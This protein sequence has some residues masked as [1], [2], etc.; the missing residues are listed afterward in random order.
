MGDGALA[1]GPKLPRPSSTLPVVLD[2]TRTT[3]TK[4]LDSLNVLVSKQ[5]VRVFRRNRRHHDRGYA[6]SPRIVTAQAQAAHSRAGCRQ[7]HLQRRADRA[8]RE[9]AAL[10]C[11]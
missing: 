2:A 3:A 1:M 10:Q 6:V 5:S 9:R 11:G 8:T 7:S 4:P